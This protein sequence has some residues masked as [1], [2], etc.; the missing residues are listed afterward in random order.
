MIVQWLAGIVV[1]LVVSPRTWI[2]TEEQVHLHVYMAVFLGLAIISLPVFLAFKKPG[3]KITRYS[4]ALGQTLFSALLIHLSGGRIETHFHVFGSLA[5]LASYRDPWV[6]IIATF[7]VAIDHAFRGVFFPQSVFGIL[8]ASPWRWVEHAAWVVFEVSFLLISIR[9]SIQ[10]MVLITS[11]QA[12]VEA[13]NLK[14]EAEVKQRTYELEQSNRELESF[15]YLTSHDLRE[16]VRGLANY[17]E[18]LQDDYSDKLDEDGNEMIQ[19]MI[20]LCKRISHSI[21]SILE[22]S[23]LEKQ[24]LAFTEVDLNETLLNIDMKLKEFYK[25]KNARIVLSSSLP[26]ISCNG[27]K[28]EAVFQN[29]ITN[30]IKYNQSEEKIIEIGYKAE[31]P[32]VFYVK[33]NGIGIEKDKQEMIFQMFKRLNANNNS[34]GY[35]VG[36]SMIKKIIEKHQGKIWLESQPGEGSCFFFT[37]GA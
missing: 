24:N 36:L 30:A 5:I 16:P 17:A 8:T 25:E 12:E 6:L 9:D 37:L 20:L 13:S 22:F 3:R 10:E 14:I 32:F 33:D 28:I 4:I 15:A 35:G 29:L 19:D 7:V 34:D 2:G 23:R 31:N 21:S 26:V 18:F 1:A 27:T 11:A